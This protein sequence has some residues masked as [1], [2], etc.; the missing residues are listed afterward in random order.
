MYRT[1]KIRIKKG[2]RLCKYFKMLCEGSTNLYNRGNFLIRQYVTAVDR[3]EE[4]LPLY[5]NQKE[6]YE[7]IRMVTAG[8]ECEP[9]S[10]WLTYKQLDFILKKTH[11]PDYYGIPSQANQQ[12]LLRLFKN[13]KSFFKSLEKYKAEPKQFTGRPGL[14]GYYK[15]G[16][17]STAVLTY[18]VCE[19]QDEKYLKFP[20]TKE[21]LNVGRMEGKGNLKAVHVKPCAGGYIVDVVL[22]MAEKEI[23]GNN[24]LGQMKEAPLRELLAKQETNTY[25]VAAIDPG[26]DNL[27]AVTTNFGAK[28]FLIKGTP[29]KSIN[30]YYNKR[31]AKLRSMAQVCNDQYSTNRIRRLHDRRNRKIEDQMHKASRRIVRWAVENQ[32][33]VVILGHNRFQKQNIDMGHVNNQKFVQIPHSE[34]ARML[35]YKLQEEGIALLKTEES[36][37]SKADFLNLDPLPEYKEG[38]EPPKMSG[39]RIKRGL[40]RHHDGTISNADIQG[41]ANILR[42]VFPNVTGWDRGVVDTP[43]VVRIA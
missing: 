41:A 34:F 29:L 33:D 32:V 24:A 8:S 5:E 17:E 1:R 14:P 19:I 10:R 31:L 21:R 25:R 23:S 20:C 2:H 40:Y 37:T 18:Q 9:K 16:T 30:Q 27:C 39:K 35:A 12:I 7:L 28:P 22:E 4:G 42:K 43:Y 6:A 15:K 26:V 11:D 38:E 3:L 36:Y 13:Y